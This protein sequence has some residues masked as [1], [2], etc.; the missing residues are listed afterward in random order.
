[1]S[2]TV[3]VAKKEFLDLLNSKLILLILAWYL[4][5]FILS[6]Y[7]WTTTIV[8]FNAVNPI[9]DLFIK[10]VYT[11]CYYGTLVTVVLGFT[12]MSSE[13]TGKALNTLLVKPLYRD[14]IIRGKMIAAVGFMTCI[15]LLIT[16][17]YVIGILLFIGNPLPGINMF[18]S[19]L[20]LAFMLYLLCVIFYY[21]VSML[22]VIMIKEQSLALFI[23]LLS[24]ILLFYF[25]P[26][27]I[28]AGSISYFFGDSQSVLL[29]IGG[30]SHYTMLYLILGQMDIQS[31]LAEHGFEVLKLSLYCL[32]GII[33]VHIAFLRRDVS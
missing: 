28:F 29:L 32:I 1:M 26:N 20:P 11:L 33:L 27:D 6:F 10:Y 13:I 4:I 18:L 16:F 19:G 5:I 30:I 12:S 8:S 31:V 25:I 24:W 22:A 23:G 7:D 9:N 21:S 2:N 15:F 17:F 3:A 14:T